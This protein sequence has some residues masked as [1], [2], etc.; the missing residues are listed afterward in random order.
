M[1]ETRT[2]DL[3]Q[4]GPLPRPILDLAFFNDDTSLLRDYLA[5]HFHA[6]FDFGY[7]LKSPQKIHV[8]QGKRGNPQ[9]FWAI[10]S[11]DITLLATSS[12]TPIPALANAIIGISRIL[13]N[14]VLPEICAERFNDCWTD[15]KIPPCLQQKT[16]TDTLGT[17]THAMT[18]ITHPNYTQTYALSASTSLVPISPT[19]T[20]GTSTTPLALGAVGFETVKAGLAIHHLPRGVLHE[21][22]SCINEDAGFEVSQW[23]YVLEENLVFEPLMSTILKL[24]HAISAGITKFDFVYRKIQLLLVLASVP[25]QVFKLEAFEPPSLPIFKIAFAPPQTRTVKRVHPQ[26]TTSQKAAHREKFVSLTNDINDTRTAYMDE[27]QGLAKKH[28]QSERWTRRQL[29]LGGVENG[30]RMSGNKP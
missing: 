15:V 16:S 12:H 29:Y 27:V 13:Q 9:D 14:Q 26:L 17:V 7:S 4:E 10:L 25:P 11:L 3:V 18:L 1:P 21:I 6:T 2:Y 23:Q 30:P 22:H 20:T 19:V 24:M 8:R 5:I 28:G